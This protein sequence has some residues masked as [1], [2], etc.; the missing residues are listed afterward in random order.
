LNLYKGFETG[1]APQH[2]TLAVFTVCCY[3]LQ[4]PYAVALDFDLIKQPTAEPA[5][6]SSDAH[7]GCKPPPLLKENRIPGFFRLDLLEACH[8][9]RTARELLVYNGVRPTVTYTKVLNSE[10]AGFRDPAKLP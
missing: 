6:P 10:P 5:A 9:I 3:N 8:D 1:C 2:G 7:A 4:Y